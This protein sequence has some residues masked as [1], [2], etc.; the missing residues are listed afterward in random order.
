MAVMH[1]EKATL[2]PRGSWLGSHSSPKKPVT[3]TQLRWPENRADG[4]TQSFR[5]SVLTSE[6]KLHGQNCFGG[7][8]TWESATAADALPRLC[9][10][11]C[12]TPIPGVR[13]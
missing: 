5:G 8:Q 6:K 9:R 7:A 12:Q 1:W 2:L 3:G 11:V 4:I 10:T 13:L